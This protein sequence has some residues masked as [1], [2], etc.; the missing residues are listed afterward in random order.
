[1]EQSTILPSSC[2]RQPLS[3][4]GLPAEIRNQIYDLVLVKHGPINLCPPC[5]TSRSNSIM[6]EVFSVSPEYQEFRSPE[7]AKDLERRE[8]SLKPFGSAFHLQKDLLYIRQRLAP[9]LLQT[10]HQIHT[11]AAGYFY[12]RNTWQFLDD[13]VWRTLFRFLITIGPR[14]RALLKNVEVYAPIAELLWGCWDFSEYIGIRTMNHPK[15]HMMKVEPCTQKRCMDCYVGKAF[16]LIMREK[17]LEKIKFVVP[18]GS[19]VYGLNRKATR[20]LFWAG[21][22]PKVTLEFAPGALLSRDYA[23]LS[24]RH[25]T[26][27]GVCVA[28][29]AFYTHPLLFSLYAE[30]ELER[31]KAD[32]HTC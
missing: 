23:D 1:M 31:E 4:L 27:R 18:S 17:T 29:L 8:Q 2:K 15:M 25:F 11:E 14:N 22:L 26:D 5:T 30:L 6:S 9:V 28:L 13:R 24:V 10:C 20:P 21:F 12:S 19:C 32:L 16:N 7:L 3:F